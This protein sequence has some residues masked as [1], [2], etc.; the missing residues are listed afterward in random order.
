MCAEHWQEMQRR[1]PGL[2]KKRANWLKQ[3]ENLVPYLQRAPVSLVAVQGKVLPSAVC[4][5]RTSVRRPGAQTQVF[6]AQRQWLGLQ[7]HQAAG[8]VLGAGSGPARAGLE[9]LMGEH[10]SQGNQWRSL[11]RDGWT[12]KP[13][14]LVLG[15]YPANSCSTFVTNSPV[16][17]LP[18]TLLPCSNL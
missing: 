5:P 18:W 16:S 9:V 15:Q 17:P 14:C 3:K 6:R 1:P 7:Q 2:C 13:S 10:E 4:F 12:V 11:V 8:W